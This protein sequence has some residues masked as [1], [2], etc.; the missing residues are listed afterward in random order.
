ME[1]QFPET[2]LEVI[3]YFSDPQVCH[4]FATNMRWPEVSYAAKN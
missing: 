2:L 1:A 3:R 4:E